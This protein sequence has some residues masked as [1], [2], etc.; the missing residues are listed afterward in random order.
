MR[1]SLARL[2]AEAGEL[3]S[4]ALAREALYFKLGYLAEERSRPWLGIR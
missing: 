2:R 1:P 4:A 3:G